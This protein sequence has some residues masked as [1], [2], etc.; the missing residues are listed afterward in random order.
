[1]SGFLGITREPVY[2]PGRVDDDA[3]ILEMVASRLRACGHSVSIFAADESPWPEP[4][5]GTV[6]FAMCQGARALA[7][8]D[9][10]QRRGVRITN[11]PGAIRNCQ[12]HR[13]AAIFADAQTSYPESVLVDTGAESALPAW[14]ANGGAWVKRGDVH[15]TET[16][17]VVAVDGVN[18]TRDALQGLR[19][20]GIRTA[21]V[22]RHV[23]GTVLKF[24]AVRQ[25]F[26][27]CVLP[28][29]SGA[30]AADVLRRIDELG[31]RA[32]RALDVEI[33]GGDCVYDG[34]GA[35]SLIDLNDWP[36]YAP[37]RAKAAEEIAAYLHEPNVARGS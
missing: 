21:L 24:Y 37:C 33:Y 19:E 32:A 5:A 30:I 9:E 14:A 23:P 20:R 12:R 3:A 8:L 35:L 22:Q 13:T 25:R 15:A 36:S 2:S 17:D 34:N 26:F 18:A 11:T 16:G 29:G 7:Q 31:A 28:P 4:V 1:M 27:H 6:V 10:W